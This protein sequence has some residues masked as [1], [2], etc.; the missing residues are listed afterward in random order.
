MPSFIFPTLNLPVEYTPQN[1]SICLY[2][3]S[4]KYEYRR[5]DRLLYFNKL[6]VFE[7]FRNG[8]KGF[9][10][11]FRFCCFLIHAHTHTDR[12]TETER[13]RD[14]ERDRETQREY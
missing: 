3:R 1:V 11:R 2:L 7:V 12:E 6:K 8:L 14:T 9:L 13:Q 5:K 10:L 4:F